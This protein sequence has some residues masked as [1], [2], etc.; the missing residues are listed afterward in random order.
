ME[1]RYENNDQPKFD[2][3]SSLISSSLSSLEIIHEFT[4]T[5]SETKLGI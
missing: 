1:K 2:V 3:E 5:Y 4:E